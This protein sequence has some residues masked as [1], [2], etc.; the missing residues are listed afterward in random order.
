[1]IPQS[2]HYCWFGGKPLGEKELKCIDSWTRF[3]PGYKIIR[4]DESNF[5]LD[6]CDYVREAY[7]AKKWAFVSDYARFK[8]LYE[9]GGIYFDT[10]VEVIKSFDDIVEKGPFM[11]I[12]SETGSSGGISVNPGLGLG[13]RPFMRTYREVLDSYENDHFISADGSLCY[14]TVVERVTALLRSM[15]LKEGKGVQQLD[16]I[17]IYPTEY[18][19]PINMDTGELCI[20]SRTHS[21]HHFDA[22]WQPESMRKVG[23]LKQELNKRFPWLPK[24]VR[25]AMAWVL[26]IIKTGDIESLRSR[27]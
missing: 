27:Y 20:T 18:F 15:G 7:E 21:I 14:T 5:N 10:D 23:R 26:Y 11:G 24:R 4:W 6:C 1:M 9:Y 16:G 25:F 19:S 22:S 3:F 8:V 12:E 13:A 17:S 2:I